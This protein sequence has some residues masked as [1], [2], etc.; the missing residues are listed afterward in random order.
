MIDRRLCIVGLGL[1]GGSLALALKGKTR[2]MIGVDHHAATRQQALAD[3][4]V[5]LATDSLAAGIAEADL[6]ILATP[7]RGIL[8]ALRELPALR[9]E[10]CFLLDLGSTKLA[11]NEAMSELPENFAALGGHPMCGKETA[12]YRAADPNLF[13]GKTFILTRNK[14]S[15]GAIEELILVIL[16]E[17]GAKSLF[18]SAQHHDQLAAAVSHL[19]YLLSASLM[20]FASD[21]EDPYLWQT[22][23][24]GFRDV[25]RLAGSDPQMLLDILLTNKTAILEQLQ[26]YTKE[27]EGV[28]QLL[29]EGDEEALADW[30]STAQRQY[31][32]YRQAKW[33][34]DSGKD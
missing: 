20:R 30:L 32:G 18:L 19:P 26:S 8:E 11:I 31:I 33:D 28:S 14:R 9:P 5:D 12:G 1:M 6:V 24:S 21:Q 3:G 13:Q 34:L 2:H 27:L 4:A 16:E 15:T 25:S 17:I 29:A 22:S 23:A 7:V 10:G